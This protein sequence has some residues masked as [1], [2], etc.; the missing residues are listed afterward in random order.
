[1]RLVWDLL[2]PNTTM[3][4][5]QALITFQAANQDRVSVSKTGPLNRGCDRA[6]TPLWRVSRRSWKFK[7]AIHVED[8][9]YSM[10]ICSQI[11]EIVS[12]R[13]SESFSA[14]VLEI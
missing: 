7:V 14:H 12:F 8:A 6:F 13:E 5:N 3:M 1:M 10:C 9:L 11:H 2:H 4:G